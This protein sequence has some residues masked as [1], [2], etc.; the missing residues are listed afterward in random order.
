MAH[1]LH[2][3]RVWSSR[4]LLTLRETCVCTSPPR[5]LLHPSCTSPH[6]PLFIHLSSPVFHSRCEPSCPP[7]APSGALA[8]PRPFAHTHTHAR[9]PSSNHSSVPSLLPSSLLPCH[10]VPFRH[11]ISGAKAP[12]PHSPPRR[13]TPLRL[14]VVGGYRRKDALHKYI[15]SNTPTPSLSSVALGP[16]PSRRQKQE[17]RC[18]HGRRFSRAL[19]RLC[20]RARPL[21]PCRRSACLLS[22]AAA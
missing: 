12:Q 19:G 21:A 8:H 18:V 16:G 3:V 17:P 13:P 5:I 6:I 14:H 4:V 7:Q 15:V 11:P 9:T 1:L 22:M 2:L 10:M 20:C